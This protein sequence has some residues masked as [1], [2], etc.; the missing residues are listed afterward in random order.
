MKQTLWTRNFN[1]LT[2]ASILGAAGGIAGNFALSFLVYD[3]T[4]ST[5][6][7]ALIIAIAV[8]PNFLIPLFLAPLMDRLPRKPFLVMGHFVEG[9]LYALAGIY[10][11]N[12]RFTYFGYLL[13]SLLL[14]S[15]STFDSLAFDCIFPKL[16]PDDFKEKG[17]TVSSMIFPVMQVIMAPV[18]AVLYKTIGVGNILLLQGGLSVLAAIMESNIRITEENHISDMHFSFRVWRQDLQAAVQYLRKEKGLL[19]IYSYMAVTNGVAG[20]M[21]PILIAFFSVTPGFSIAMYSFFT[22]A[23]FIGRSVGGILHYHI[24]IPEKKRFS[25]AY[26]VYQTYEIMDMMLL[27]LP[28]PFML[29]NRAICGFLGINSA[30]MRQAAVQQ[31]I[32]EEYRARLNAF[33][34]IMYSVAYSLLALAVGALGEVLSYRVCLTV[35]AA[36]TSLACVATI[37]HGRS[38]VS[39]IYNRLP[40]ESDIIVDL[41]AKDENI[42]TRN[43][44]KLA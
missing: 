7:A 23:E 24:K 17:Y 40:V 1:L 15:L 36:F 42:D 31:Y 8:I 14:S 25:F 39:K 5:L 9:T 20:G 37:W 41:S 11:L 30:I 16:I 4:K 34:S 3:K 19:N 38:Q 35:C 27:W 13:F 43:N 22:V 26:F 6:A 32:P 10:L 44:E 18:A 2:S 33:E 29:V 21:S 12:F 28:Y